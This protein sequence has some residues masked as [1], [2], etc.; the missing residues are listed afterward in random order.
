MVSQGVG[1]SDRRRGNPRPH[2]GLTRPDPAARP[3]SRGVAPV[4]RLVR[5]PRPC[6]RPRGG[7]HD[8]P[9]DDPR[10]GP[11]QGRGQ[12]WAGPRTTRTG[13]LSRRRCYPLISLALSRFPGDQPQHEIEGCVHHVASPGLNHQLRWPPRMA[14]RQF[15]CLPAARRV[16]GPVAGAGALSCVSVGP[17]WASGFSGGWGPAGTVAGRRKARE[18][19]LGAV[20]HSRGGENKEGGDPPNCCL[21]ILCF[22]CCGV[23][24]EPW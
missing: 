18:G 6:R 13:P 21:A 24:P 17:S 7:T 15:N 2:R 8:A 19:P 10:G 20:S 3:G 4:V 11:G 5:G 14:V 1:W 22:S 16:G 23:A 12:Q 9:A